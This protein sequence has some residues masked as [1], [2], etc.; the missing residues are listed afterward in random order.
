VPGVAQSPATAPRKE[1][2]HKHASQSAFTLRA[3]AT[4]TASAAFTARPSNTGSSDWFYVA[5][6]LT[7]LMSLTL[8]G[9]SLRPTPRLRP[10]FA[11]DQKPRRPA[12][13]R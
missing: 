9:R 7:T 8:L 5:V 4:R 10:A 12:S 2:A 6:G 1:K 11:R 3:P 13:G